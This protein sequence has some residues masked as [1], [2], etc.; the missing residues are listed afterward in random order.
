[1]DT[2]PA[3][4]LCALIAV[5]GPQ[6][7]AAPVERAAIAQFEKAIADYRGDADYLACG[8]LM[9]EIT[10]PTP[11]STSAQLNNASDALAGAIQRS[12]KNAQVGDV[13]VAAVT[14]VF[15]RSVDD[16]VRTANLREVLAAIDDE[17]PV[18]RAPKIHL[19][20]PGAAPMATMPPSLLAALP[21][22]PKGL[23]YRIIGRFLVLRDVDAALIIDYIPDVIPR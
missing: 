13:F 18:V 22:L 10:G 1:M 14:P 5:F 7:Q 8:R 2:M 4:L 15:K 3:V 17:D 11:N 9:T 6:P 12:R 20:F 19:R 16:A 23:E 21:V